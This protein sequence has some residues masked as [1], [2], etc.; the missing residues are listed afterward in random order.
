MRLGRQFTTLTLKRIMMAF[1]LTVFMIPFFVQ[2][3]YVTS[4]SRYQSF[5]GMLNEIKEIG[6]RDDFML[7]VSLFIEQQTTN[8]DRLL[9]FE[10]DWYTYDDGYLD[11]L[12]PIDLI[13]VELHG[14]ILTMNFNWTN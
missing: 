3:T 7:A 4:V 12:R 6:G 2:T 11:Q 14:F 13:K 1:F 5:L 8:K 10:S 9:K